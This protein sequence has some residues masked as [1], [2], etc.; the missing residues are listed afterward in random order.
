MPGSELLNSSPRANPG[1]NPVAYGPHCLCRVSEVERDYCQAHEG[2][3]RSL[4]RHRTLRI[5]DSLQKLT[6]MSSLGDK[7]SRFM[8]TPIF[9]SISPG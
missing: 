7:S 1:R 3:L 8:V 6:G 5:F 9:G 2:I 4:A